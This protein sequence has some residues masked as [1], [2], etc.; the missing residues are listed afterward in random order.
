MH[1]SRIPTAPMR[2]LSVGPRITRDG[3]LLVAVTGWKMRFLT[4]SLLLTRMTVDPERRVVLIERRLGWIFTRRRKIKFDWIAAV[5]YGYSDQSLSGWVSQA[6]DSFDVF[7]VGL[8][9]HDDD[10]FRLFAFFGNGT[11]TNE[12]IWPD[13]MY[14]G[15]YYADLTGT[16]ESESRTF[17]EALVQ[18]LDVPLLP[19]RL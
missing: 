1:W 3:D 16:Q 19:P 17:A 11:F 2:L 15:R 18:I 9:L 13:W 6:H 5:T 8:R 12:S 14:G 4:L 7:S 10:E